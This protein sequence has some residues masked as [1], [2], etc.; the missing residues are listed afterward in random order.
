[1]ISVILRILRSGIPK[2]RYRGYP[3]ISEDDPK[4]HKDVLLSSFFMETVVSHL[5][6][7]GKIA[8]DFQL[9]SK[10]SEFQDNPKV[11]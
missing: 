3:T 4:F 11:Y 9:F 2:K 1:M 7:T 5:K 10:A 6:E 8:I